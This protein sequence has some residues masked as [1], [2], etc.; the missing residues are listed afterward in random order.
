MNPKYVTDVIHSR[1]L[2]AMG[3]AR[4]TEFYW[5]YLRRQDIWILIQLDGET[6]R[7]KVPAP[8]TDELLGE[9]P[10]NVVVMHDGVAMMNWP[11]K[12]TKTIKGTPPNALADLW[13]WWKE[14]E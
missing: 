6:G 7:K 12:S 8:L 5:E 10:E 9:L 11:A 1:K 13:C 14:R 3:W 2:A 4:E